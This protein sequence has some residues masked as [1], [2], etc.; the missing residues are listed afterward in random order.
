VSAD[1][2]LGIDSGT[3]SCKAIVWDREGK[4][5]SEGRADIPMSRPR[6]AWH[7]QSAEDWW[8]S[9]RDSIRKAVEGT[10]PT[11]LAALCIANQRE[12][13]VAVDEFGSPLGEAILWMDERARPLLGELAAALGAAER[14]DERYRALSGKTLSGNLSV[15]KLEWLRR[16]AP[17]I[18]NNAHKV[19]DVQAFLVHRL[20]GV[21]RTSWASADPMGLFDMRENRWS[22]EILSAIGLAPATMP[23]AYPPGAIIA[24]VSPDAAEACGLRAGTPI[25]SGLGDGQAAGLGANISRPGECYLSLGTSI[26]SGSYSSDYVTSAAFRAMYGGIPGSYLLETVLLGGGYTVK[27]LME[28]FEPTAAGAEALV[29]A[30]ARDL[31]P[32]AQGLMLVPYWNSAMNPYWDASA[33]GI[34]I[35]WRGIHR[36]E[37]LYRA[38][39]EGAAF[40]LRLHASGVEE[41]LALPI[42]RYIAVGGGAKSELWCQIIADVTGKEVYRARSGEGAALGAGILAAAAA[43]IHPSVAEAAKAMVHI[44]QRRFSPDASRHSFYARLYEEVYVHLFPALRPYVDRLTEISSEI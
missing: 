9:A 24:T 26:V 15:G 3:S 17:E 5:V 32:G 33:S 39:L 10:D 12:S 42:E 1:L 25:V 23:E 28:D 22:D 8:L 29:E 2:V 38:I 40:E 35:G 19:L 30:A 34:T 36:K 18:F 31:P 37:H 27:W 21:F 16:E 20:S 6:P 7:E 11:R 4:A 41:A 44:D 14:G 13:F 43:G